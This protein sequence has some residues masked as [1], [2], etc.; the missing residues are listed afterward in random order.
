M[1]QET[2]Q[3]ELE[4][5]RREWHDLRLVLRSA[6][7]ARHDLRLYMERYPEQYKRTFDPACMAA[8]DRLIV[9]SAYVIEI[10]APGF[11]DLG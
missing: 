2:E 7:N 1:S 10:N 3:D 11:E 4:L 6:C 5:L 9:D 8:L